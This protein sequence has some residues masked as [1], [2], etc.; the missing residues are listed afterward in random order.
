[1]QIEFQLEDNELA[2]EPLPHRDDRRVILLYESAEGGAGV[3]H[4]L[5]GDPDALAR[6]ARQA[7]DVCHYDAATG[8]VRRSE[9]RRVGNDCD[10]SS[11]VCSSDLDPDRV[12]A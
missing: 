9:E 5:L 3:L 2:A 6:V 1:I 7:L 12:P 4:R 11:D 8:E 10:W